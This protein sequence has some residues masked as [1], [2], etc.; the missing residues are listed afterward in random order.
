MKFN[1]EFFKVCL[2]V[3]QI[4]GTNL[5][6]KKVH[7]SQS[8][9]YTC[10]GKRNSETKLDTVHLDIYYPVKITNIIKTTNGRYILNG[11]N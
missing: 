7:R 1:L 8:G 4:D 3:L 2:N 9:P 11:F 10:T 6:L 5:I